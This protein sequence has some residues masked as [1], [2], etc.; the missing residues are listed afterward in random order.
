MLA[1]VVVLVVVVV[2]VVVLVVG[3]ELCRCIHNTSRQ[4]KKHKESE[5]INAALWKNYEI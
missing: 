3:T 4:D 5:I 1:V 2:V